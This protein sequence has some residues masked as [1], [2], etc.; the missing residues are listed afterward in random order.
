MAKRA[1]ALAVGLLVV[2]SGLVIQPPSASAAVVTFTVTSTA[3]TS[4][5]SPGNG[6]CA[7]A[8][9][10]CTLRAAIEE[11]NAG[12]TANTYT[13]TFG[14]AGTTTAATNLPSLQRAI[15]LDGSTA[16]GYAAATGPTFGV[17]CAAPSTNTDGIGIAGPNAT[18]RA[19]RITNCDLGIDIGSAATNAKVVGSYVGNDGA[20]FSAANAV[21]WGIRVDGDDV[22]IGGTTAADRNVISG[23]ISRGLIIEDIAANTTVR[24]NYIGT[25]KTGTTAIMNPAGNKELTQEVGAIGASMAINADGPD[26]QIIGNVVSGNPGWGIAVSGER[27]AVK[28]N[29]VGLDAGGTTGIGNFGVG[30]IVTD[31]SGVSVGGTAA[32]EGNVVADIR[33]VPTAPSL[34]GRVLVDISGATATVRGNRIGTNAAGTAAIGAPGTATAPTVGLS[35]RGRELAPVGPANVT[36]GGSAAGAANLISGSSYNIS[37]DSYSG[38]PTINQAVIQGNLIGTNA[39]GTGS[40]SNQTSLGIFVGPNVAATIGG[41]GAGEGNVISGNST[42]F[43][44]IQAGIFVR[45]NQSG[46][47]IKGNRVGTNATGTA[48]LAN[49]QQGVRIQDRPATGLGQPPWP[50]QSGGPVIIGGSAAGAGNLLSGNGYS[51]LFVQRPSIVQGNRIG[52]NAA[53]TAAIPNST[54]PTQISGAVEVSFGD[55]VVVG[56]SGTGEG[57]LISGNAR[58][59]MSIFATAMPTVEGNKIGTNAAGTG[60]LGNGREGIIASG[61]NAV[62]AIGGTGAGQPN[63]IAHNAAQ[64]VILRTKAVD[65]RGNLIHSNGALSIDLW[66][67]LPTTEYDRAGN[68]DQIN[69]I[70]TSASAGGGGTN[71]SGTVTSDKAGPILV[72]VY[73]SNVCPAAHGTGEAKQFLGTISVP[74]AGGGVTTAFSGSVAASTVGSVITATATVSGNGTSQ[75][76]PCAPVSDL[77][78]T[79]QV[80]HT[81]SPIGTEVAAEF[82]VTNT[83]PVTANAVTVATQDLK[84]THSLNDEVFADLPTQGSFDGNLSTWTIGTLAPGAS[85]KVCVRAPVV[86]ATYTTEIS[87]EP[88]EVPALFGPR[89]TASGAVDPYTGNSFADA[90]VRVGPV[91]GATGVCPLPTLTIDDA[92]V[93]RPASGTTPMTF[94]V[95]L[96]KVQTRPVKVKYATA[97][98]KAVAVEDYLATTGE[99][100]IPA[101]QTTGTIS[102]PI[103]GNQSDEPDKA[104]T[105]ELSAPTAATIADASATGTVKANHL[106]QGCPP[107]STANQ[108]FVCHLYFDALGRAPES[109]GF[110]YWV[111]KLNSGTPRS[112]MAKS[113]LTQSESLRKVADRAYVLY[114]G[115]HGTTTE[116]TN[117]ANKLKA[118]TVSTQD[119]RIAVLSS[120]EY[121]AKT[122]GTNTLYIQQMYRDVFRRNVDS[123]GLAYW[124]GQLN[125]GKTRANVATRFMAEAE[126]KRKIVGDIYLRFLRR[127][128]TTA[129]A[130]GWVNQIAAGKTE[131]DVGIGL[132]ASTEYYNRPQN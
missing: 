122:G 121:Y 53:G 39:A 19:L 9:A 16:P 73:A 71:V 105:L 106:L 74:Y 36:V 49:Q 25:D 1:M 96:S 87:G 100:T 80:S 54:S 15:T 92:S 8:A 108:R 42:T 17:R 84:G 131:V 14:T 5:A 104:F 48:A 12:S 83:G 91:Q 64:G 127:E 27:T 59:G 69:P 120:S 103:V 72:D 13:V 68:G 44:V 102:V 85:A 18:V 11:A 107:G 95:R 118:K 26:G 132:V 82:T 24:G 41:A 47:S 32:G 61:T 81:Q 70:L 128:P 126:G 23:F 21:T 88:Y 29:I 78:V 130:T 112:T 123:S 6:T 109:G 117:W 52:T 28:G 20:S 62:G 58:Y 35:I 115:R 99:L 98:G 33:S 31:A 125:A 79:T 129:E 56:G 4:D 90:V 111:G 37:L 51:G 76:S 119:I 94:T 38:Q 22:T 57:N 45:D 3:D 89:F 34:D 30:I 60:A 86:R 113:Y 55:G 97:N 7:T 43:N 10:A 93:T 65:V 124:V 67:H 77:A 116:L 114:L 75:F 63:L 66:Q 46:V 110:T 101:G 40:L 50:T 2:A